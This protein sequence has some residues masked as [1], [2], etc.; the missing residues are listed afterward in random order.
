M[1]SP[2]SAR[3]SKWPVWLALG[4]PVLVA[5]ALM[6]PRIWSAQFG[7]FDDPS[8]ISIAQRDLVRGLGLAGRRRIWPLPPRLL[9]GVL[10]DLRMGRGIRPSGT[11]VGTCSCSAGTALLLSLIVLRLTHRPSGG[12]RRRNCVRPRRARDRGRLHALQARTA[13]VLLPD[14]LGSCHWYCRPRRLPEELGRAGCCC[15]S[16]C[17]LLAA[18]TK[19][20]TG[21]CWPSLCS[22]LAIAWVSD[23]VEPQDGWRQ[24]FPGSAVSSCWPPSWGLAS[25]A[26]GVLRLSP[27]T[28]SARW[29]AG[30][31]HLHLGHDPGQREHLAGPDRA[32]LASAAAA[33]WLQPRTWSSR[34]GG[35]TRP[36]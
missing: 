4:I 17:V 8:S 35:C 11:S 2:A 20:T 18:L 16:L 22:W 26:L 14:L 29:A 34:R 3:I 13:A 5:V 27:S 25:S 24:A 10:P 19:E 28:V 31:L 33:G 1:Q 30:Q 36:P 21:V 32:R 23:R 9:A 7:L 15:A 12:G 6:V